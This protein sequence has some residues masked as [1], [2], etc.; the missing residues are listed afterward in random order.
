MAKPINKLDVPTNVA[1]IRQFANKYKF[2][3]ETVINSVNA[4]R[5]KQKEAGKTVKP[6]ALRDAVLAVRRLNYK[7]GIGSTVATRVIPKAK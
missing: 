4:Y 7:A 1:A 6:L 2:R 3:P 5:A